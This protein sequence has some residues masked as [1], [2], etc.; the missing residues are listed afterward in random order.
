MCFRLKH[1]AVARVKEGLITNPAHVAVLYRLCDHANTDTLLC[2][3]GQELLQS[4]TRFSLATI[5]KSIRGLKKLGFITA[6]KKRTGKY[7]CNHYYFPAYLAAQN[8]G[9]FTDTKLKFLG[10][11]EETQ[12]EQFA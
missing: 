11:K 5:E 3:P 6:K 2:C 10:K 1:W 12:N 4:E 7:F 9:N 8:E